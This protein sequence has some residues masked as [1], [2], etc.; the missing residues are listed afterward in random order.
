[1]GY[2]EEKAMLP[3][4]RQRRQLFREEVQEKLVLADKLES[5][6][7]HA[8]AVEIRVNLGLTQLESVDE[9]LQSART[10]LVQ[11]PQAFYDLVKSGA[12]T[13]EQLNTL[14]TTATPEEQQAL[15]A[16]LE[17][18]DDDMVTIFRGGGLA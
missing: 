18:T 10:T 8:A 2:M 15:D 13:K 4:E 12:L 14:Q 7:H 1:M 6:G 9:A 3:R 16:V 11:N 5:E 17:L